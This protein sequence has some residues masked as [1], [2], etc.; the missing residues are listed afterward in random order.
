MVAGVHRTKGILYVMWLPSHKNIQ[1]M[2]IYTQLV[3]W[4]QRRFPLSNGKIN[5]RSLNSVKDRIWIRLQNGRGQALQK[6]QV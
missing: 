5:R 1:N 3:H 4:G 2:L 6:A